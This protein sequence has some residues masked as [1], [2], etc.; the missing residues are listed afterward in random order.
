MMQ[1]IRT[2]LFAGLVSC[3]TCP[4]LQSRYAQWI[5]ANCRELTGE[6]LSSSALRLLILRALRRA[7][8]PFEQ[9]DLDFEDWL[10]LA[11]IEEMIAT[12]SAPFSERRI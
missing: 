1:E 9:T 8:Y 10:N 2:F 12:L 5:C 3:Q 7:G 11:Q 4:E 6:K